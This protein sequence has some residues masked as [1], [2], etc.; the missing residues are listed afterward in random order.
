[1]EVHQNLGACTTVLPNVT[2]V[3]CFPIPKIDNSR[4]II[5]PVCKGN[6]ASVFN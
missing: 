6:I 1:M 4:V 3:L 2:D 5:D